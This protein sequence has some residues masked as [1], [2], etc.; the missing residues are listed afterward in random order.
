V[1]SIVRG[2][3]R[4]S[5]VFMLCCTKYD[6]VPADTQ[7]VYHGSVG[8]AQTSQ[9]VRASLSQ[10][11][12]LIRTRYLRLTRRNNVARL[13]EFS[14]RFA[15]RSAMVLSRCGQTGPPGANQHPSSATINVP[16][17]LAVA[18]KRQCIAA[19]NTGSVT[20]LMSASCHFQPTGR[21]SDH[22][23][24][25]AIHCHVHGTRPGSAAI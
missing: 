1:T 17:R 18:S 4:D 15:R 21:K 24:T 20:A 23:W 25:P 14:G 7:A 12:Q 19:V 16:K 22:M 3:S 5:E 10:H 8:Y 13:V 6:V 9:R 2:V 11:V